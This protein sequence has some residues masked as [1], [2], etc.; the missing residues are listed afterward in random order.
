MGSGVAMPLMNVVFGKYTITRPRNQTLTMQRPVGE[1]LY[2]L[3]YPWQPDYEERV[4]GPVQPRST[5]HG[6]PV[7]R[8]IRLVLHCNGRRYLTYS[9]AVLTTL[10]AHCPH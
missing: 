10:P 4:S 3:L 2:K 7:H 6:L 1:Q 5:L 8:Q 9:V